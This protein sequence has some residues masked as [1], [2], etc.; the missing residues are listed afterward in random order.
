MYKLIFF[1]ITIGLV[2]S[3]KTSYVVLGYESPDF[4]PSEYYYILQRTTF[5]NTCKYIKVKKPCPCLCPGDTIKLIKEDDS[6][7]PVYYNNYG[8]H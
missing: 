2:I 7:V 6:L 3:C 4:Y 8:R 1:I 5:P